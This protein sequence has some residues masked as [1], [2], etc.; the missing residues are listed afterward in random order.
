MYIYMH[1]CIYTYIYI[2]PLTRGFGFTRWAR[3]VQGAASSCW[4]QR[5]RGSRWL[6]SRWGLG[7][8]WPLHDTVSTNIVWC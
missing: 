6:G 8:V 2:Q 3:G 4:L 1:I 7:G 5:A